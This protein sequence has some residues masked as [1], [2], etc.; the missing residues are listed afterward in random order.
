MP[1]TMREANVNGKTEW[2]QTSCR[3]EDDWYVIT[4]GGK[5]VVDHLPSHAAVE[6]AG[7]DYFAAI[8]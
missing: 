1:C 3:T 7:R 8:A 5:I 4:Y 6:Q 2:W